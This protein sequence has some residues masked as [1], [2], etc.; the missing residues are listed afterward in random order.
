MELRKNELDDE[1][2]FIA[3]AGLYNA[4]SNRVEAIYD[5][6]HLVKKF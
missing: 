6:K 2:V 5:T 1:V 4:E 3:M